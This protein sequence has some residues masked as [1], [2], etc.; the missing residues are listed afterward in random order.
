[1]L[2]LFLVGAFVFMPRESVMLLVTALGVIAGLLG[3]M[4]IVNGWRLRQWMVTP[5]AA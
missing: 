4:F 1:V 5:V 2:S 3:V